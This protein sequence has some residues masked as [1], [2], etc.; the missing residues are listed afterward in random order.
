MTAATVTSAA[1]ATTVAASSAAAVGGGIAALV[2]NFL[3]VSARIALLNVVFWAV[4]DRL[5]VVVRPGDPY[6]GYVYAQGA[7]KGPISYAPQSPP[8]IVLGNAIPPPI[9]YPAPQYPIPHTS[10]PAFP[11]FPNT[12]TCGAGDIARSCVGECGMCIFEPDANTPNCCCDQECAA[13]GDCCGDFGSCCAGGGAKLGA[14]V[15]ARRGMRRRVARRDEIRDVDE[16]LDERGLERDLEDL[17][18]QDL[19]KH[20]FE[21]KTEE[22]RKLHVHN[23]I[24]REARPWRVASGARAMETV[25]I[26]VGSRDSQGST[27]M[28]LGV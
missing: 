20:E 1:T 7:P 17:E 19:E 12:N 5:Y 6:P 13:Y 24:A 27:M 3:F 16:R 10:P 23:F 4:I 11:P 8:P 26:F 9:S 14:R 18:K 25:P 28:N 21:K 2:G 15:D 22:T